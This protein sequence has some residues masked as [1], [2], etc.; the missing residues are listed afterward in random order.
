MSPVF[1]D[2]ASSAPLGGRRAEAARNDDRILAAA[3]AVFMADPAAPISAVA[4]RAGVGVGALY[5]RYPSKEELLRRLCAE[6]LQRYVA[7]VEAA[8]AD[9]GDV[10][11]AFAGFMHAAV[12][13]DTNSLT[14]RLAGTFTPTQ[15]LYREADRAQTLNRRLIARVRDAG[16][17]RAD[18]E[19]EDVGIALELVAGLRLGDATRTKQLRHRYLQLILDGLRASPG[20]DLPG[21]GPT[22]GELSARWSPA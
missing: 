19:A 15:E 16:A 21:P 20:D 22:W 12:E 18:V 3:R 2:S 11:E 5:R 13:A 8:L 14:T 4:A 17:L 10:W 9:E 7:V 6:G 1:S